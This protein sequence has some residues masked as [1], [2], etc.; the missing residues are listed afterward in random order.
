[1]CSCIFFYSIYSSSRSGKKGRKHS[2]LNSL[3]K[4][5]DSKK[6]CALTGGINTKLFSF[7]Y[8]VYT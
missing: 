6:P 1:M 8:F 5:L 4:K 2:V 3:F 7:S